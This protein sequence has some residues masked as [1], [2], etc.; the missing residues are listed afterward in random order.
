MSSTTTNQAERT[1]FP[2]FR[3]EW[4]NHDG[5][6]S[7]RTAIV[8]QHD[9]E[10][11]SFNLFTLKQNF[12]TKLFGNEYSGEPEFIHS[13]PIA[14][15]ATAEKYFN[16][17][18]ARRWESLKNIEQLKEEAKTWVEYAALPCETLPT[19]TVECT[20]IPYESL[21]LPI[22]SED[23]K[24]FKAAL[25]EFTEARTR[26]PSPSSTRS[27][28]PSPTA[29]ETA[30]TTSMTEPVVTD[31]PKPAPVE[32]V[33][34][35]DT[36][37]TTD[38]V[39]QEPITDT[40]VTD[41]KVEIP[42][43][44][45][46]T[47]EE[48]APGPVPS[49]IALPRTAEEDPLVRIPSPIDSPRTVVEDPSAR[50][51]SPITASHTAVE[52]VPAPVLSPI[53][54][55]PVTSPSEEP[56]PISSQVPSKPASPVSADPNR[57]EVIVENDPEDT[58]APPAAPRK[59]QLDTASSTA[60][61]GSATFSRSA[62]VSSDIEKSI[63]QCREKLDAYNE[64]VKAINQEIQNSRPNDAYITGEKLFIEAQEKAI[65]ELEQFGYE[66]W[67]W[68]KKPVE[69]LSSKGIARQLRCIKAVEQAIQAKEAQLVSVKELH[70]Q[71]QAKLTNF[72]ARMKV[73]EDLVK[74]LE[75]KYEIDI[76]VNTHAVPRGTEYRYGC[77]SRYRTQK[78]QDFFISTK[79]TI[80][81][82]QS[83]IA[84]L[85]PASVGKDE[86]QIAKA[87]AGIESNFT[88]YKWNELLNRVQLQQLNSDIAA[89]N[90]RIDTRIR[91]LRENPETA[92]HA[93]KLN[94]ERN[95]KISL[96]SLGSS[97]GN[98]PL[99]SIL[100]KLR[101]D[102][103]ELLPRYHARRQIS[104]LDQLKEFDKIPNKT[105]ELAQFQKDLETKLLT[106]QKTR[107]E[108]DLSTLEAGRI[109][110]KS[111]S[112]SAEEAPTLS[113]IDERLNELIDITKRELDSLYKDEVS[114]LAEHKDGEQ[115]C[116]GFTSIKSL[117][118]QH[119]S[120]L[121]TF[122]KQQQAAFSSLEKE[123]RTNEAYNTAIKDLDKNIEQLLQEKV[124][125]FP[126]IVKLQDLKK[127]IEAKN[128][129]I[130]QGKA[131]SLEE[132]QRLSAETTKQVTELIS[133]LRSEMYKIT[134]VT[135]KPTLVEQYEKACKDKNTSVKEAIT[136]Y[137]NMVI[138]K[139]DAW[140]KQVDASKE[141]LLDGLSP[142]MHEDKPF[143]DYIEK[144]YADLTKKIDNPKICDSRTTPEQFAK[145]MKESNAD[146]KLFDSLEE[147]VDDYL[148]GLQAVRD[149]IAELK[150][151]AQILD[152]QVLMDEST[153]QIYADF[154]F[155]EESLIE[156]SCSNIMNMFNFFFEQNS[157]KSLDIM[158]KLSKTQLMTIHGKATNKKDSI[159]NQLKRLLEDKSVNVQKNKDELIESLR[160]AM[161][162]NLKKLAAAYPKK[163]DE[164]T[165]NIN[166]LRLSRSQRQQQL[167]LIAEW[168]AHYSD[169]LTKFPVKGGILSCGRERWISY[170]QLTA[171]QLVACDPEKTLVEDAEHTFNT[172]AI[173]GLL[174]YCNMLKHY[175]KLAA[176]KYKELLSVKGDQAFPQA[177]R[178]NELRREDNT[179]KL[180][181]YFR[182]EI[183]TEEE[184]KEEEK[185]LRD[186]DIDIKQEI[187]NLK[188]DIEK[189][190]KAL[191]KANNKQDI[192]E[193]N[194]CFMGKN[195]TSSEE[196]K[197]INSF[198][199]QAKKSLIAEGQKIIDQNVQQLQLIE[200]DIQK[201]HKE[202]TFKSSNVL[203]TVQGLIKTLSASKKSYSEKNTYLNNKQF[204]TDFQT[205]LQTSLA[206]AL[207][208]AYSR[209]VPH[210]ESRYSELDAFI[211]ATNQDKSLTD[212]EIVQNL[213]T[214][215]LEQSNAATQQRGTPDINPAHLP[216]RGPQYEAGIEEAMPFTPTSISTAA[217]ASTATGRAQTARPAMTT[218][219]V[220]IADRLDIF[221]QINTLC[222][223]MGFAPNPT[224]SGEVETELR[225]VLNTPNLPQ[226]YHGYNNELEQRIPL[227]DLLDALTAFKK[228]YDKRN[229]QALTLAQAKILYTQKELVAAAFR[230]MT[231][232]YHTDSYI[233]A[234]RAATT[235]IK[236]NPIVADRWTQ[237]SDPANGAQRTAIGTQIDNNI[238]ATIYY[239]HVNLNPPSI[240]RPIPRERPAP[241]A[242]LQA[243]DINKLSAKS[244]QILKL[245]HKKIPELQN[246]AKKYPTRNSNFE[247]LLEYH[248]EAK[249]LC[250]DVEKAISKL[251]E[252]PSITPAAAAARRP[253]TALPPGTINW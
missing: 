55:V 250:T 26:S 162:A 214:F 68:T 189:L 179:I 46:R 193:Q 138:I 28:S 146:S 155:S 86:Q 174:H 39:A 95:E 148:E 23:T 222:K 208:D 52:D 50:V 246:L 131:S 187:D 24:L 6:F 32:T 94:K 44:T 21:P 144:L 61:V 71:T 165:K 167:R 35:A 151:D 125:Q 73:Y 25:A 126:I 48:E 81:T 207:I 100:K 79:Q 118:D 169:Y 247:K 117:V 212:K 163:L 217:P 200:K 198:L 230:G 58:P 3:T 219:E 20:A 45:T 38:A 191:T 206:G 249:R 143:A 42:M 30:D 124:P 205:K 157:P 88:Y 87:I 107:Y 130:V 65:N 47:A 216:F 220:V 245:I 51:P 102:L 110:L 201:I 7:S 147:K 196:A 221:G 101:I 253:M 159:I 127:Q 180:P 227:K 80:A 113:P 243:I 70:K 31:T 22:D 182:K 176:D 238:T 160:M 251:W 49:P 211:E 231:H 104:L 194:N 134:R 195:Q 184:Q 237:A 172:L 150:A 12:T 171:Q 72:L 76:L 170:E 235:V 164:L 74:E 92:I 226:D 93:Y 103:K 202:K 2:R 199:D 34:S 242:G 114:D 136:E 67:S 56:V 69:T 108:E 248:T 168:K 183:L 98:T 218:Q 15:R 129:A 161:I 106:N 121:E 41:S 99:S 145:F 203:V 223:E 173:Y 8:I 128:E 54:D 85:D 1:N 215:M 228:A 224:W 185:K 13:Q 29:T 188:A 152:S 40:G 36:T 192:N 9:K 75:G 16:A 232:L 19:D 133:Q 142:W 109:A 77:L 181:T 11:N 149:K 37:A 204:S 78:M 225:T 97:S 158:S 115:S 33:A 116:R 209:Y 197:A 66:P 89:V 240:A 96:H 123:N 82:L 91:E 177:Y 18:K 64:T 140:R 43:D 229:K 62:S 252:D 137:Y 190:S 111:A 60:N 122:R 10:K 239:C 244:Q 175:K 105:P 135:K 233:P 236:T 119:T 83:M 156:S 213:I 234:I 27:L 14:D 153:T 5:W 4:V 120:I 53:L 63:K 132:A 241:P 112:F 84:T 178:A 186:I 154:A 59:Q 17:L 166:L 90:T 210:K 139:S 57:Y 141:K